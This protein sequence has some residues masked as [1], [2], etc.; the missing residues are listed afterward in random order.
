MFLRARIVSFHFI[1][2]IYDSVPV[3]KAEYEV[4]TF[5]Y[6]I[7]ITSFH[8]LKTDMAISIGQLG[9]R[10][11]RETNQIGVTESIEDE[12]QCPLLK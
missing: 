12:E 8:I 4:D 6:H 7:F 11:G 9:G 2:L 1:N 3:W 10:R 5:S